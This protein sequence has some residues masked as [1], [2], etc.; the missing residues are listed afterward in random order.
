MLVYTDFQQVH[1]SIRPADFVSHAR[2]RRAFRSITTILAYTEQT[3]TRQLSE[4]VGGGGG[5]EM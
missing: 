2:I 3:M 5:R 1:A 4:K